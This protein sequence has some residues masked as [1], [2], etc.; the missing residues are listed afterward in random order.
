MTFSDDTK[1][2]K[3]VQTKAVSKEIQKDLQ[4]LVTAQ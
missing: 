3:I 1:P 4:C 2:S